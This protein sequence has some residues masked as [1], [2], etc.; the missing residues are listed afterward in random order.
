MANEDYKILYEYQTELLAG[1]KAKIAELEADNERL[2][3]MW[4]DA[5]SK[6]SIE[7]SKVKH[8]HCIY[9]PFDGDDLLW[10]YHCSECDT[11][12]ANERNYCQF[13]GAVMDGETVGKPDPV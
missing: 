10:L 4:A 3:E 11:P 6:L 5:V 13:C 2:R 8:G 9:K 7:K 12:S 1:Y